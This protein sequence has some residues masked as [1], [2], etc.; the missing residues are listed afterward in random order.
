MV[1]GSEIQWSSA[2]IPSRL[3]EHPL[4]GAL[5]GPGSVMHAWSRCRKLLAEKFSVTNLDL[6]ANQVDLKAFLSRDA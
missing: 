1:D 2:P 5:W 4:N 6:R 3:L